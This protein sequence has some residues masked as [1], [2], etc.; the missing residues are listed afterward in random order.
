MLHLEE[1]VPRALAPAYTDALT[2]LRLKPDKRLRD[3]LFAPA[4]KLHPAKMHLGFCLELVE[5]YTSEGD[6]VLDPMAGIGTTMVAA[7][8]GRKVVLVELEEHFVKPMRASWEVMR[9]VGPMQGHRLGAVSI[10]QGDA[11]ALDISGSNSAAA[12]LTSPPYGQVQSSGGGIGV[13]GHYNDPALARRAYTKHAMDA[14]LTS[15]PY[16]ASLQGRPSSIDPSKAVTP[17]QWGSSSAANFRLGPNYTDV[18]SILTSPPYT[19]EHQGGRDMRPKKQAG[20]EAGRTDRR[21]TDAVITSPPYEGAV[22]GKPGIDWTRMNNGQRD[23]TKE[24]AQGTRVASLSEYAPGKLNIGNLSGKAYWAAMEQVYRECHRVLRPNGV[25]I[26]VM[27]DIVREH[28][29]VP[30]VEQTRDLLERVGFTYQERVIRKL[31]ALSFW[32]ILQTTIKQV[33]THGQQGSL[34]GAAVP[35]VTIKRVRNG[36]PT[37]ATETALVLRKP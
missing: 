18:S 35:V 9:R 23:L 13:K 12:V 31:S 34:D 30:L 29:V 7:L 3:L 14:V 4:A 20:G 16:G 36:A 22:R 10:I 2:T 25:C 32:R 15:P 8:L 6:T 37:V 11:R 21:Y 17:K 28:K 24:A 27:K 5:R 1:V 33:T 19:Q 26:V